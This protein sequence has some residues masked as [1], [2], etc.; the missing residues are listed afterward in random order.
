MVEISDSGY[1][2]DSTYVPEIKSTVYGV[3]SAI[4]IVV[5]VA[6]AFWTLVAVAFWVIL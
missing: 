1:V 2:P 4:I 5:C 3:D 6:L